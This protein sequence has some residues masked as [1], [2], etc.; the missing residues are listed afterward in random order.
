MSF[1][2]EQVPISSFYR[3]LYPDKFGGDS[4]ISTPQW[5]E[6]GGSNKFLS[7]DH[8]VDGGSNFASMASKLT[9]ISEHRAIHHDLEPITGGDW[10]ASPSLPHTPGT[11]KSFNVQRIHSNDS[12]ESSL[13]SRLTQVNE[14]IESLETTRSNNFASIAIASHRKGQ[15]TD[16]SMSVN[17][18]E[19]R[20]Y[21]NGLDVLE[22]TP[23]PPSAPDESS[24]EASHDAPPISG[25]VRSPSILPKTPSGAPMTFSVP[26]SEDVALESSFRQVY[27]QAQI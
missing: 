16:G 7:M 25:V 26:K 6:F 20:R 1:G 9:D 10:K 3:D 22:E 4:A 19:I 18:E 13:Q 12:T 15:D 11:E 21:A 14:R 24:D 8:D 2:I 17:A 27:S 5:S 23:S